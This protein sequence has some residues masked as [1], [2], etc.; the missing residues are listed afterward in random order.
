MFAFCIVG[1]FV[2]VPNRSFTFR[3]AR[4]CCLICVKK[5]KPNPPSPFCVCSSYCLC[6]SLHAANAQRTFIP[7]GGF[8][9]YLISFR[10]SV[11]MCALPT[12]HRHFKVNVPFSYFTVWAEL[13]RNLILI[14]ESDTVQTAPFLSIALHCHR[15]SLPSRNTPAPGF[16][17]LRLRKAK[18]INCDF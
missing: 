3:Q 11:H 7:F 4:L 14:S 5:Q 1:S 16:I 13:S 18:K 15:N 9:P 12:T 6:W 8:P 10:I 17:S 2:V